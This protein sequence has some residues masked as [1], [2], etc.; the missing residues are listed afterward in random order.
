M[1]APFFSMWVAIA[2]RKRG[3]SRASKPASSHVA[4]HHVAQAV[5]LEG[6]A[7]VGQ[8]EHAVVGLEDELR[9]H[10]GEVLIDPAARAL[11]DRHHAI[12]AALALAHHQGPAL[13]VHVVELRA[14]MSS[15]PA[16]AGRVEGLQDRAIA[17]PHRRVDVGLR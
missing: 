15:E 2:W 17:K 8:E 11:A 16:D 6:L 13:G 12:L 14:S 7:V 9:A 10:F 3:R 1:S 4:L 5:L